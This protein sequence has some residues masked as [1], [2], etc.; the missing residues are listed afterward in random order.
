MVKKQSTMTKNNNF[1]GRT[2]Q[3]KVKYRTKIIYGP[4]LLLLILNI[5]KNRYLMFP[6]KQE[7]SLHLDHTVLIYTNLKQGQKLSVRA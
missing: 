1:N 3:K 5:K 6:C 7:F 4:I 2:L